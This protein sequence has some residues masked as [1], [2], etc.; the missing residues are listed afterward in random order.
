[1]ACRL[2]P[3][4]RDLE[5]EAQNRQRGVDGWRLNA[6]RRQVQLE[7]AQIFGSRRVGGPG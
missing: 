6:G 3:V 2:R 1:M 5:E 4:E 7:R